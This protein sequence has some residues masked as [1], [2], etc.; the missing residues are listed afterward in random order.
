MTNPKKQPTITELIDADEGLKSKRMLLTVSSLVLLALSFADAKVAEANSFIFKITF[1]NDKGLSVLLVIAVIFL[2]IRYY[3]Y[4]CKYHNQL[5]RIWSQRMLNDSFFFYQH[6]FEHDFSGLIFD[7][8]LKNF[9]VENA[10]HGAIDW[11]SSYM[12][13]AIFVRKI[14]FYWDDQ[15]DYNE[16]HVF[17]GWKNY[18]KV[19]RLEMKY[20]LN[21]YIEHRESLD[22]VAPYI[23]GALAISSYFFNGALQSLLT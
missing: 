7:L 3:N 9:D 21:S 10:I 23:L 22:I 8:K 11:N 15:H 4:A 2:L 12:C 19:L 5:Y 13:R 18:F 1:G 6:P 20:Q 16:E 14:V 17:V